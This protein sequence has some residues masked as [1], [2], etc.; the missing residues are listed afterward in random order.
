MFLAMNYHTWATAQWNLSF[1]SVY[2][3]DTSFMLVHHIRVIPAP[4]SF[5][6]I[7]VVM[8][9]IW[10]DLPWSCRTDSR[11]ISRTQW[12]FVNNILRYSS[13]IVGPTYNKIINI[14][15]VTSTRTE[16]SLYQFYETNVLRPSISWKH[17]FPAPTSYNPMG[18]YDESYAS[19][20]HS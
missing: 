20:L 5:T 12:T 10:T 9:C 7:I 11:T 8:M 6:F 13:Q 18:M 1:R 14:L 3:D 16:N 15:C 17:T 2:Y 4:D 19:T